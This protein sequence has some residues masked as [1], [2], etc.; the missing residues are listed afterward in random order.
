MRCVG[1]HDRRFNIHHPNLHLFFPCHG[2]QPSRALPGI[3]DLRSEP[4]HGLDCPWL[5]RCAGMGMHEHW[6]KSWGMTA[7][8]I[9][10]LIVLL[11]LAF[12]WRLGGV[13]LDW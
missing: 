2:R 6:A 12:L 10:G 5:G 3:G 9:I 11:L 13:V 8:I 7:A 4:S 1:L